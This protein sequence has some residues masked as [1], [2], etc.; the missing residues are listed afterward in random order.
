MKE[1]LLIGPT[2]R[3][4]NGGIE[5][6]SSF[7]Q[8]TQRVCDRAG[9]G[10]RANLAPKLITIICCFS[11]VQFAV[12]MTLAKISLILGSLSLLICEVGMLLLNPQH[13]KTEGEKKVPW[14][15]EPPPIFQDECPSSFSYALF[16]PSRLAHPEGTTLA[17][18][19]CPC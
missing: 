8:V 4:G 3:I 11:L 7:S 12:H 16:S 9:I 14:N 18:R 5:R 1:V 19:P 6:L 13:Q 17:P 15:C 2:D 10:T